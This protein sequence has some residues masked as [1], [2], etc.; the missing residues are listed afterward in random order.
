MF[1]STGILSL[2]SGYG[3]LDMAVAAYFAKHGRPT[4]ITAYAEFDA[5]A[6]KVFDARHPGL[7]NLGDIKLID[8]HDVKEAHY[9]TDIITAGYPCQPFS[10]A[11][12]RAGEDDPRHLWPYIFEAIRTIQPRFTILENVPGHR[13]KGFG[14]VL[15]DMAAEGFDIRWTSVRASDVGAPHRRE[16]VFIVARPATDAVRKRTSNAAHYPATQA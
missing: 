13:S 2:C 3:G 15:G 10:E 6:A 9:D 4:H 11:G 14:S 16:R 1:D 8:W 5:K 12:K 7:T